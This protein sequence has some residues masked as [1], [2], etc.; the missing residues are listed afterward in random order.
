VNERALVAVRRGEPI[1]LP[2]D[3]VYGIAA[4]P[5]RAQPVER[6][7]RLKGRSVSQPIALLAADVEM[8]FELVPELDE[9]ARAHVRALLPGALTLVLPNPARRFSWLTGNRGDTIGMR[10]PVLPD[11]AASLVSNVCALAATS[12]N[13]TGERDPATLDEVP[14]ELRDACAAEIDAGTL[15]GTPSTVVDLTGDEPR[16]LREG[17]VPA[18]EVLGRVGAYS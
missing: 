4:L 7:S 18:V 3:T 17:A 15:P 12:A 2:T 5:F 11:A 9:R 14:L 10:V 6:L 16:V 13:L 8:V 1:L